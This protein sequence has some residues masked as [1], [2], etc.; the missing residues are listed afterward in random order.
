MKVTVVKPARKGPAKAFGAFELPAAAS[1]ADLKLA[2][3]RQSRV[4]RHRV[5]LKLPGANGVLVVRSMQ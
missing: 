3:E 5:S 1:V 2:F 4:S